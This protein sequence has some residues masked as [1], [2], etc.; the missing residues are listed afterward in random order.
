[1]VAAVCER[2]WGRFIISRLLPRLSRGSGSRGT[3]NRHSCVPNR[4][5]EVENGIIIAGV[6]PQYLSQRSRTRTYSRAS[7]PVSA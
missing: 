4:G 3:C 5:F 6:E 7:A 2:A 1:M